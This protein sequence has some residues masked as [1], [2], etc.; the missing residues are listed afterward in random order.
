MLWI[1]KYW[2]PLLAV[3]LFWDAVL[4]WWW[5]QS[6]LEHSQDAPIRNA[7]KRYGVEPALIKA[8][9]WK[10]SRFNPR[11]IGRV[12]EIG[13]MQIREM[14]GREWAGAEKV[15]GFKTESLF[16]PAVN[17]LVGA[18]YLRQALKRYAGTDDPLPYA[19]AD[20]NA[21][22][23]N[24]LKWIH[25]AARTNSTAFIA[26]IDFPTTQRYVREVMER[27]KHYRLF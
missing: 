22:R 16:D 15:A 3:V 4:V 18:W 12:Q 2:V 20:Y 9:I 19:L 11:A 10:E 1:R 13:L 27:R 23:G 14:T 21:G 7:A 24:V 8:V 26:Q 17:T 25:G 6:R 5:W